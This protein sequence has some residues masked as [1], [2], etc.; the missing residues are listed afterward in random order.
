MKFITVAALAASLP[1]TINAQSA[2]DIIE[3]SNVGFSGGYNVVQHLR[4]PDDNSTCN[5]QVKDQA[6]YFNGS[7]QPFADSRLSVHFRGPLSLKQF[8]FYSTSSFDV[9]NKNGNNSAWTQNAYYDAQSQTNRN[10]TFTNLQGDYSPCMG[11]SLSLAGI[12]GGSTSL[13]RVT[14]QNNNYLY[15]NQELVLFSSKKCQKSK[16]SKNCGI[17]RKGIPAYLGFSGK[18]KMFLFEW[19]MPTEKARNNVAKNNITIPNLNLPGIW[20]MNDYIPRTGEYP[21]DA[22][23]SCFASGCGA[24][25]IFKATDPKNPN[26]LFSNVHILQNNTNAT[27]GIPSKNYIER[28]T[29]NATMRGG[30]IIDSAGNIISFL[31]DNINFGNISSPDTVFSWFTSST[32]EQA[33]TQTLRSAIPIH[34]TS[35][36]E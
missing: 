3:F 9:N 32:D 12:D 27:H 4:N 5:C 25:D 35:A 6:K 33:Y 19:T 31:N 30:V 7:N 18:V 2:K 16:I 11:P 14:L 1:F 21:R 29:N 26:R 17:Y 34:R 13:D 10:I 8:A 36:W 23:C 15:S 24:Y 22:N 28:K 20:L